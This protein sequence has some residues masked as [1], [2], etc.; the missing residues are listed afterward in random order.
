MK[1]K[2]RKEDHSLKVYQGEKIKEHLNIRERADYTD[3]Q[4]II[5]ETALDKNCK[6]LMIDGFWGSGKTHI[7]VLASLKLLNSKKVDQILYIRNPVESSSNSKIGFL[8]GDLQSKM[9]PYNQPLFD[10]VNE[11]LPR[12]QINELVCKEKLECI[13]ISFLQGRSFSCKAIIVD[14]AASLS[15]EDLMLAVSRCG[16]FTKIFFIGDA[17]H[18][19][20][21]SVKSGFKRFFNCFSDQESKDNGVFT[22][23]LKEESDVV[24]SKFLRFIM[25][26]VNNLQTTIK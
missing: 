21:Q 12:C 8:Q 16:E 5:L 14:E 4:K 25:N 6:C 19:L 17:T 18:Q 23:E 24:R 13:P 7:A 3:K 9:S 20:N 10:K 22:F 1:N 26:R 11:F 2:S 15:W